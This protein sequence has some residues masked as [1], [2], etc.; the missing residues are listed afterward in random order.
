MV[1]SKP[2]FFLINQIID[3]GTHHGVTGSH[4]VTQERGNVTGSCLVDRGMVWTPILEGNTVIGLE[5]TLEGS[6][7]FHWK[8]LD[9]RICESHEVQRMKQ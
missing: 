2:N 1:F 8:F 7:V 5:G 6:S 4:S 9:H 3:V